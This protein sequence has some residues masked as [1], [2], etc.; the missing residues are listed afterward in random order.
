MFT[1]EETWLKKQKKSICSNSWCKSNFYRFCEKGKTIPDS[2]KFKTLFPFKFYCCFV[3]VQP[4]QKSFTSVFTW[5]IW[6][7]SKILRNWKSCKTQFY[8]VIFRV[9][10]HWASTTTSQI[11]RCHQKIQSLTFLTSTL[12]RC[13]QLSLMI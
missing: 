13:H 1:A 9:K 3:F 8:F 6:L 10:K 7:D 11:S 2:S 4:T 5:Q 12:T